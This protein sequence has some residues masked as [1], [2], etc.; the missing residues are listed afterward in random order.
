[1]DSSRFWLHSGDYN[2]P[3]FGE[4]LIWKE[5]QVYKLPDDISLKK[6]CLLEPTSIVTRIMD[7][8]NLKFGSRVAVCGGGPI[9]LLTV[10][11]MIMAGASEL[12]LIAPIAARRELALKY[13]A[14]HVIDSTTQDL[15]ARAAEITDDLGYDVVVDCSGSVHAVEGLLP[16]TAKCGYLL[17][18]AQYPNA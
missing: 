1:M 2:F 12:T 13:G 16:I 17:Y 3:G 4:Y 15:S 10:Q 8:V 14:D 7:K 5:A 9:G 6:G 11:A 18:A